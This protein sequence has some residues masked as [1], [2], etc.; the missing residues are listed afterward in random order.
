MVRQYVEDRVGIRA[1]AAAR[2][3][4]YATAR[5][6]LV[7]AGVELRPKGRPVTGR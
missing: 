4:S 6:R 1:L 3:I 2:G 5:R 7:E